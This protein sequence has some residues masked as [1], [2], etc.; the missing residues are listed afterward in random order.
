M[1]TAF[2]RLNSNT[3][4]GETNN[5]YMAARDQGTTSSRFIVFDL[6]GRIISM[7]QTEFKQ[8][9]PKSG[10]VEHDPNLIL[11]SVQTCIQH[12]VDK[13]KIEG[14]DPERIKSIGITN[15][16]ETTVPWNR[17]TGEPLHHAIGN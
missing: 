5:A 17:V 8:F 14:L 1:S 7:H 15:Q 9:Y 6:K 16:R 4:N 2:K 10:W 12:T 3:A 11:Q 13:M